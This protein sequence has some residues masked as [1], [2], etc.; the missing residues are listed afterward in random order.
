[1]PT[2]DGLV[3]GIDTQSVIESLLEIRQTQITRLEARKAEVVAKQTSFSGVESRLLALRG[4]LSRLTNVRNNALLDKTATSSDEDV[5]TVAAGSQALVGVYEFEVTQLAAAHTIATDSLF[6]SVDSEVA[7]GTLTIQV[8]N[9]QATDIV[10]NTENNTLQGL[11]DTINSSDAGV[12]ASIINTND[13]STPYR[14]LLSSK[15]SGTDYSMALSG[16]LATSIDFA[17]TTL[18]APQNAEVVFGATDAITY[19]SATNQ[20]DGLIPGVTMNLKSVTATGERLTVTVDRDVESAKESV[21]GIVT[22]YNELV[23]FVN[24]QTQFI[25][26]TGQA[27][28]LLGDRSVV[29]VQ[30]EVQFALTSIVG[31]VNGNLNRVTSIGISF[32]NNGTIALDSSKLEKA[33]TGQIDGINADDVLRLFSLSG[34]SNRSGIRYLGG[35]SRTQIG[36]FQVQVT[37]AATQAI[38]QATNPLAASIVIDATNE[39]FEFSLD[40]QKSSKLKL[41]HGTYTQA[42][43]ATLLE[44]AINGDEELVGRA[45]TVTVQDN[46]LQIR[47][48]S[49]G[50]SSKVSA[51][52]GSSLATLGFAGT[53][54]STG[55]DVVG[56]FLV[57]GN[58]E[59]ALGSGQLLTGKAENKNT[60]DLQVRVSLNSSQLSATDPEG[61]VSI[62]R[63]I[64]SHL[65]GVLNKLLQLPT[66]GESGGGKIHT[67]NSRYD[68]LIADIDESIKRMN[69]RFDAEQESLI[70][71]FTALETAVSG[72][73]NT[74]SFLSSQLASVGGLRI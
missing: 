4:A 30:D 18:Q 15:K 27:G 56:H 67:A 46:T 55:Q 7:T 74:A 41:A 37:S 35:S 42:Q 43:A 72:F 25:S 29:A 57:N 48:H 47:S 8:G 34:T 51:L 32:N 17:A 59:E 3:T 14:L 38:A 21:Q 23:N 49:Y 45:V 50:T 69:A 26:E 13:G 20:I 65:D 39:E 54:S 6:E 63:G 9:A 2:I 22:A 31:G 73:Q 64:A 24:T 44:D 70:K 28:T 61:T 60:A 5:M 53:E 33:L 12:N 1:V 11:A 52:T 16:D 66:Q 40:G 19:Y 71:Q 10:I 68:D 36:D 58:V 62:T